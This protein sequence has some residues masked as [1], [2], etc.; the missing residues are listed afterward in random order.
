ME[1]KSIST[2]RSFLRQMPQEEKT[3][4]SLSDFHLKDNSRRIFSI[5]SFFLDSKLYCTVF[6]TQK[7]HGSSEHPPA[8]WV[9][10]KLCQDLKSTSLQQRSSR[11]SENSE[12]QVQKFFLEMVLNYQVI[13]SKSICHRCRSL[14][15]LY[16][17]VTGKILRFLYHYT[18]SEF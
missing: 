6:N 5:Q 3:Q 4:D 14:I 2:S 10:L 17:V 12:F 7:T 1:G 15:S 18:E 16:K 8:L 9:N 13:I 11:E